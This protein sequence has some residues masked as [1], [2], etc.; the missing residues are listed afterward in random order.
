MPRPPDHDSH[1]RFRLRITTLDEDAESFPYWGG[2]TPRHLGPEARFSIASGV[3]TCREYALGR[4]WERRDVDCGP[5]LVELRRGW[6]TMGVLV[7]W[8]RADV[9]VCAYGANVDTLVRR[10]WRRFYGERE[11]IRWRWWCCMDSGLFVGG[12]KG[13]DD[14]VCELLRLYRFHPIDPF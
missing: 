3:S 11:G 5:S 10:F 1:R 6:N 9:E 2:E 4:E 12:W 7:R 14:Y 8:Y 13:F